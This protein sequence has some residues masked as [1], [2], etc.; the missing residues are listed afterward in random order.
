MPAPEDAED[1][2]GLFADTEV[3]QGLGKE[4]VSAVDDVRAVI[5]GMIGGWRTDGLGAFVLETTATG[6]QR[7]SRAFWH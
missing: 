6:Q 5:E 2:Y 4:P 1:L 7:S 3:M